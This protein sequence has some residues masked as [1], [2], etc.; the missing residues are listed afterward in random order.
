[1]PSTRPTRKATGTKAA[2]APSKKVT[3]ALAPVKKAVVAPK[4]KKR[5]VEEARDESDD[6]FGE[7]A[8][9]MASDDDEEDMDGDDESDDAEDF[10]EEGEDMSAADLE[11][12]EDEDSEGSY[13]DGDSI[14]DSQEE[15]DDEDDEESDFDDL[16]EDD[17]DPNFGHNLNEPLAPES[18]YNPIVREYPEIDPVYDSDSSTEEVCMPVQITSECLFL[19]APTFYDT[20]EL[21]LNGS[22]R[23]ATFI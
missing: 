13:M 3:P 16:V 8:I 6:E 1:M 11:E 15:L 12:D 20:H 22:N 5:T 9:D 14:V 17:I 23:F 21:T 2:P 4:S 7:V 18:D 10:P 19:L